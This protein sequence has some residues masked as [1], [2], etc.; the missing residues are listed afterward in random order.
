M[1]RRSDHAADTSESAIIP[2][3]AQAGILKMTEMAGIAGMT[4]VAEISEIAVAVARS[5]EGIASASSRSCVRIADVC[6]PPSAYPTPKTGRRP[7]PGRGHVAPAQTWPVRALITN[8]LSLALNH[9]HLITYFRVLLIPYRV[10]TLETT[11]A[12]SGTVRREPRDSGCKATVGQRR[13]APSEGWRW[14]QAACPGPGRHL[15][16]MDAS[17]WRRRQVH[18]VGRR[19]SQKMREWGWGKVREYWWHSDCLRV[20]TEKWG[21][22]VYEV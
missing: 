17:G 8:T 3:R 13:A 2:W 19:S 12:R 15:P 4:E 5:G 6:I 11:Q 14:R 7:D 20:P 18:A 16:G 1:V 22:P 21:Q 9:L 10:L